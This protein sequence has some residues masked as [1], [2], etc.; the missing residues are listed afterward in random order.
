LYFDRWSL[1]CPGAYFPALSMRHW[2]HAQCVR[3][4]E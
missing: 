4:I 3:E 1:A 2:R